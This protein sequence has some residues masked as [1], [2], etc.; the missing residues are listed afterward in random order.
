MHAKKYQY[1]KY[2]IEAAH[3]RRDAEIKYERQLAT[4]EL[5][6]IIFSSIIVAIVAFIALFYLRYK[7]SL[8]KLQLEKI[9]Y[10]R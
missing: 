9:D 3:I 6:K 4:I 10:G 8:A 2:Q 5:N 7:R 1:L